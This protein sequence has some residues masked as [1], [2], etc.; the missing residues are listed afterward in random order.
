MRLAR[1]GCLG[2]DANSLLPPPVASTPG[3]TNMAASLEFRSRG[4]TA[5]GPLL[6]LLCSWVQHVRGREGGGMSTHVHSG[7]FSLLGV[8][9]RGQLRIEK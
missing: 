2:K 1:R 5:L 4:G 7:L 9:E 8:G 3:R 6:S